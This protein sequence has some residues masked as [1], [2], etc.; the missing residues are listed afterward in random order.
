MASDSAIQT[1]LGL[2]RFGFGPRGDM[3][4]LESADPRGLFL[5][6]IENP[7]LLNDPALL[8]SAEAARAVETAKETRPPR[9]QRVS[10]AA[11]S[12]MPDPMSAESKSAPERAPEAAKRQRA[13]APVKRMELF[14]LE[15][16]A[17]FDKAL[18]V[19]VGLTERLVWF[20][21]NHFCVSAAKGLVRPY[22]GPLER[23]AIRPN[24][25]GRFHDM[26]L[27]VESHPA[28]LIY[29]DNARSIGPNSPAGRNRSRGLNENL[30]REILELHTLGVRTV[31]TQEDVTNFAKVIT[32][33]G[34]MPARQDSELGGEF[35]FNDRMHEP[36]PQ[37]VLAKTYADKGVEQGK[38][39]LSDLARHPATARH[40]ASKLVM[41]FVADKPPE[42]LVE[43]L[44]KRFL[45]TDG[46]L[47]EVTR[48]MLEAKE[49]W[50]APRT[51]VKRPSEWIIGCLRAGGIQSADLKTIGLG[52]T[53]LGEPL[54]RPSSPKGFSDDSATWIDGI[55]QRVDIAT[56]LSRGLPVEPP[57]AAG[58]VLGSLASEDTR[59]TIARAADRS[60]AMALLMMAPEFQRR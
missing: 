42:S 27:T 23:E 33:W 19:D 28:M 58:R 30:A 39:V 55:A 31:Y 11:K 40:I 60:Q 17:R 6:D 54:W 5:A 4:S 26:L 57:V 32:G 45:E 13:P 56:R 16:Q 29:L 50:D 25:L 34:M 10:A 43:S 21:S 14:T 9:R 20:W 12:T 59:R 15:S 3:P 48:T 7:P 53:A 18:S 38:E 44:A 52:L 49:S 2:H 8:G 36:G 35:Y 41:H 51:K 1:L 46:D 22:C 47:K 37:I 24:V